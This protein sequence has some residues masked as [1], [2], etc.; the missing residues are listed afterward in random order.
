MGFHSPTS[1]TSPERGSGLASSPGWE[2]QRTASGACSPLRPRDPEPRDSEH[3]ASGVCNKCLLN[4]LMSPSALLGNLAQNRE[5]RITLNF[6]VSKWKWKTGL[7]VSLVTG[8]SPGTLC[9]MRGAIQATPS[10]PPPP[11][12]K[13]S[14]TME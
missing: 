8:E 12:C 6:A 7:A 10:L 11:A 14:P 3:D 2:P 13:I 5:E 4:E 9:E 1:Q